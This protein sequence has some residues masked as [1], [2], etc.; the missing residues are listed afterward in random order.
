MAGVRIPPKEELAEITEQLGLDDSVADDLITQVIYLAYEAHQLDRRGIT[1]EEAR[2]RRLEALSDAV[3]G[4]RGATK[5][6]ATEQY[7]LSQCLR[8]IDKRNLAWMIS[9]EGYRRLFDPTFGVHID[10]RDSSFKDRDRG[11]ASTQ[12][13][14]QKRVVAAIE[15]SPQPLIPRMLEE[16]E[17]A[18]KREIEGEADHPGGRPPKYLRDHVVWKLI[19][20]YEA[21]T[22]ERATPTV[23]GKFVSFCEFVLRSFEMETAGL[24]HAAKKL[25]RGRHT[26][27]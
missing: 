2:K 4:L 10:D 17:L 25:L 13:T 9:A 14:V 7:L 18:L 22:Q 27:A 3:N 16:I 23:G 12:A 8:G 11:V 24:D 19:F 1:P 20:V 6:L 5:A 26:G 15:A 21:A